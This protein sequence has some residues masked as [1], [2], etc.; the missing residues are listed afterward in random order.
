M[1]MNATL[2]WDSGARNLHP[3][4]FLKPDAFG[5]RPSARSPN[6]K[7]HAYVGADPVNF[8]D[9]SGLNRKKPDIPPKQDGGGT[10]ITVTGSRADQA[11]RD[12]L[13]MLNRIETHEFLHARMGSNGEASSD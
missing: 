11:L 8:T 5:R 6:F 10:T 1:T 12:T 2:G 3:R 13:V 9:P 7:L 4:V